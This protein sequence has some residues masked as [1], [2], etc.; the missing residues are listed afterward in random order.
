MGGIGQGDTVVKQGQDME[1]EADEEKEMA[2]FHG[3]KVPS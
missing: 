1:D 3:Q 2:L